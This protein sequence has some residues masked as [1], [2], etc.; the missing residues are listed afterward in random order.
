MVEEAKAAK[1]K[2]KSN[3]SVQE[4]KDA[5]QALARGAEEIF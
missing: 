3:K 2:M 5:E 4:V 1:E